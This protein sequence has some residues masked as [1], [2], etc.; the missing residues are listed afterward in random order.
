MKS[1]EH[2]ECR[3]CGKVFL[4]SEVAD[5]EILSRK[6]RKLIRLGEV[7][8]DLARHNRSARKTLNCKI[9]YPPSDNTRTNH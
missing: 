1:E 3:L 5:A 6:G 7:V 9:C 4:A 8:H 2:F